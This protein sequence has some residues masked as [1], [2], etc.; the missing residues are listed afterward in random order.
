MNPAPARAALFAIDQGSETMRW[1]Y[2][3]RQSWQ[4]SIA[5]SLYSQIFVNRETAM[6]SN[7][8]HPTMLRESILAKLRFFYCI[9]FLQWRLEKQMQQC[10]LLCMI[11]TWYN[12]TKICIQ[13]SGGCR[14]QS[15]LS[16]ILFSSFKSHSPGWQMA[17]VNIKQGMVVFSVQIWFSCFSGGGGYEPRI[18]CPLPASRLDF[19][20]WW[21]GSTIFIF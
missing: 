18:Y 13:C 6:L 7:A 3:E 5:G 11:I 21:S 20:L 16:F 9:S 1:P 15:R 4:D 2:E 17:V 14:V 10:K 8:D 12:I 19:P